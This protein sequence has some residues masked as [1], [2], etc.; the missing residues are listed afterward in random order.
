MLITVSEITPV[1]DYGREGCDMNCVECDHFNGLLGIAP[2]LEIDC[3]LPEE[4]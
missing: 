4:D 3:D 1:S 2:N